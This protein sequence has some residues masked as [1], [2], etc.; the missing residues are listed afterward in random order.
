MAVG[1]FRSILGGDW[2]PYLQLVGVHARRVVVI[3]S[4]SPEGPAWTEDDV[5]ELV[6]EFFA[7][8]RPGALLDS[9]TSDDSLHALVHTSLQN[10]VSDRFRRTARGKLQ[11]RLK[12]LLT[13][14][15]Y[16]EHPAGHWRRAADPDRVSSVEI[17]HLIEVVWGV[18]AAIVRWSPEARRNGPGTDRASLLRLLE[19]IFDEADGAVELTRLTT[20]IAQ[21]VGLQ[22]LPIAEDI[23]ALVER[24]IVGPEA[25]SPEDIAVAAEDT[26]RAQVVAENAWDQLS[27][28]ERLVLPH[29][30]EGAR[31]AGT[32]AGWGKTKAHGVINRAREKLRQFLIDEPEHV[33]SQ[34]IADLL[35]RSRAPDVLKR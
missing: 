18:D 26:E 10:L 27:E 16:V 7:S 30:T 20:V 31:A 17:D 33:R 34:V 8:P 22:A 13:A 15:G 11:R 23:D 9:A 35:G 21:R 29:V 6:G 24:G 12:M 2:T 19:S 14:A 5:E 28:E 25:E 32:A 4:P 1:V 3:G